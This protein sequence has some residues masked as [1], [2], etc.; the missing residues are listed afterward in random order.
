MAISGKGKR[1]ITIDGQKLLWFVKL[2]PDE[3][4]QYYLTIVSETD[5]SLCINYALGNNRMQDAHYGII[6]CP[7]WTTNAVT[8]KTIK[9]IYTWY[10]AEKDHPVLIDWQGKIQPNFDETYANNPCQILIPSVANFRKIEELSDEEHFEI[11]LLLGFHPF[12]LDN[13]CVY[14]AINIK[15][16]PLPEFS[17][18]LLERQE[19]SFEQL[20]G[21]L[22]I[23]KHHH[24]I[25]IHKII[26]DTQSNSNLPI[27]IEGEIQWDQQT[28]PFLAT[29]NNFFHFRFERCN[30]AIQSNHNFHWIKE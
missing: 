26:F 21:D 18:S 28:L 23:D 15:S 2:N 25:I 17:L 4:D 24:H 6:Q 13:Q 7:I 20:T 22:M 11:D 12:V 30:F 8:P 10:M 14:A 5:R 19:L 9:D 27:D 3:F 1:K 29:N 16:I